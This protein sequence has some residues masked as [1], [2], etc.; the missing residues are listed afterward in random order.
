MVVFGLVDQIFS[1]VVVKNSL[2][3]KIQDNSFSGSIT[4]T[5]FLPSE[6]RS[7]PTNNVM[8]VENISQQTKNRPTHIAQKVGTSIRVQ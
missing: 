2:K 3:L 1:V 7:V 6:F 4:F 5:L 8:D